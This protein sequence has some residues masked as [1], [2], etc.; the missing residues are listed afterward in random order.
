MKKFIS[1]M[2]ALVLALSLVACGNGDNGGNN[3]SDT[4]AS[5]LELMNTAWNAYAGEKFAAAGGSAENSVYAAPGS[6][7][8]DDGDN[9]D[10]TLGFPAD[11]A[12]QIDEAASL[13]HMMNNNTFTCGAYH[14][15]SGADAAALA[16][17]LQNNIQGRQWMCGFPD[18]L[19]VITLGDYV[20]A[21]FGG[22]EQVNNFRDAIT[23]SYASAQIAC[24]EPIL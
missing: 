10:F 15:V 6:F 12:A 8:V 19:V 18:K 24:E 4:P 16:T 7:P 9:L 20:V 14:L 1:L 11:Q 5:A 13:M 17:A 3:A 21:M 2:L 23:G 22:E